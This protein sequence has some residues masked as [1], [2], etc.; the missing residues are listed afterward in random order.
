MTDTI[1]TARSSAEDSPA[2]R[3]DFDF[4]LVIEIAGLCLYI[5][6]KTAPGSKLGIVMPDGRLRPGDPVP[7]DP[8]IDGSPAVPHVG[9]LRFDAASLATGISNFPLPNPDHPSYEVVH[10]FN[11][12]ELSFDLLKPGGN[13]SKSPKVPDFGLFAP[14]LAPRADLFGAAPKGVVMRTVL[15]GGQ[16]FGKV[17][18]MKWVL[19]DSFVTNRFVIDTYQGTVFWKRTFSGDGKLTLSLASLAGG[20][21]TT[22]PLQAIPKAGS[23][24]PTIDLK[25]ANLCATNPLEW[26]ELHLHT[27]N[28]GDR[29][30][31]WLYSLVDGIPPHSPLP[32]PV[33]LLDNLQGQLQDCFGAKIVADFP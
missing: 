2:P 24:N 6:P 33:P 9:Y 27:I 29:D 20:G 17:D 21:T 18:T 16:I 11:N 28:T 23:L 13:V 30:F 22:I 25:L 15:Y 31:K 19:G 14:E 7:I 1:A 32:Y 3:V 12:E 4:D 5:D 8:Y 26:E 10:L